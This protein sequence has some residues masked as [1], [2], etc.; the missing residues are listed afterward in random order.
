MFYFL[1]PALVVAGFLVYVSKKPNM[2][3]IQREAVIHAAPPELF[4][5][6]EDFHQWERWSPWDK[7]D[8][9]I[10]RIYTGPQKGV[11]AVYE[12]DGNKNVGQ[13]R[14]EIL[15]S[16]PFSKIKLK[17]DFINPFEGHHITDFVLTPQGDNT[18]VSWIM[19]GEANLMSKVMGT[20]MDM[21]KMIG[22]DFE[23]GLA[24]LDRVVQS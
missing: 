7:R 11:G 9:D 8:P 5:L 6:L 2:M 14:M 10:K 4:R 15:E 24:N 1:M 3:K 12:W 21:D 17:L 20:F 22:K 16:D 18:H 19:T 23:E 13:G